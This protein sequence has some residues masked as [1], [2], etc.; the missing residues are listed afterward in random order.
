MKLTTSAILTV[1]HVFEIV[2]EQYNIKDWAK[3]LHKVIPERKIM[4]DEKLEQLKEK[5]EKKEEM[6]KFNQ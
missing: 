5:R 1:N 2:A 3:T 6:K 4:S